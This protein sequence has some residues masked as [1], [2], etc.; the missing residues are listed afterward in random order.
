MKK[1]LVSY[2]AYSSRKMRLWSTLLIKSDLKWRINTW[3]QR[4]LRHFSSRPIPCSQR[5]LT[6]QKAPIIVG[7]FSDI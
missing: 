3:Y 7:N 2:I 4:K 5:R 1:K 6:R